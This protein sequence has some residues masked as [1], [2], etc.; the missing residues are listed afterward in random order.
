M[1]TVEESTRHQVIPQKND[2][3]FPTRTHVKSLA[4][5]YGMALV[6]LNSQVQPKLKLAPHPT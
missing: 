2:L 3:R 4:M 6:L 1:Q 5:R